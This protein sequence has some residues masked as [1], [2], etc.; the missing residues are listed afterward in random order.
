MVYAAAQCPAGATSEVSCILVAQYQSF[1]AYKKYRKP[2]RIIQSAFLAVALTLL[3]CSSPSKQVQPAEIAVASSPAASETTVP[4]PTQFEH[5]SHPPRAAAQNDQA[6]AALF[7]LHGYGSN[8]EDMNWLPSQLDPRLHCINVQA[9]V[10]MR[11][12]GWAWF[13]LKWHEGRVT[14]Y[15]RKGAEQVLVDFVAFAKACVEYYEVDAERV[16]FTGFSQ[17]AMMS[18]K[19]SLFHPELSAGAVIMSGSVPQSV[20]DQIEKPE[21]LAGMPMLI[22]HGTDDAIIPIETAREGLKRLKPIG[23][24]LTYKEYPGGHTVTPAALADIQKWLKQ[25]LD[26]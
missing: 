17:G 21:A 8:M 23:L 5:I 12:N 11:D 25:E 26:R 20:V 3:G 2:M 14:D 13:S 6:P 4:K 7:I 19:T 16:Y 22:T 9:P 10:P 1:S 18:L 24:N 15:D